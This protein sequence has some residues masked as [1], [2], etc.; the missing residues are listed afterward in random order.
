M[1]I[2]NRPPR[3]VLED[4]YANKHMTLQEIGTI[5][6]VSRQRVHQWIDTYGIKRIHSQYADRVKADPKVSKE[7]LMDLIQ[8][9]YKISGIATQV[10]LGPNGVKILMDQF[11]LTSFYEEKQ[12]LIESVNFDINMLP[13]RETIAELY[14]QDIPVR[15][16]FK[17]LGCT[18]GTFY[19][20]LK[21]YGFELRTTH[22]QATHYRT[23][24]YA[25]QEWQ[26]EFEKDYYSMT[27]AEL[28]AKYDCCVATIY[29]WLK[30]YNI[31]KKKDLYK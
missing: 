4:L 13:S 3:S 19:K 16:I 1:S 30:K 8:R 24:K 5:Y 7:T 21:Y 15:K 29:L 26:N 9:G 18:Q 12:K 31:T 28:C 27:T 2:G 17:T 25:P 22:N 11:G 23:I 20:W 10:G 6:G 14:Y